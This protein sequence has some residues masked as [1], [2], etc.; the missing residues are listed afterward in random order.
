MSSRLRALLIPR[1]GGR[2]IPSCTRRGRACRWR[3]KGSDGEEMD[4]AIAM[5]NVGRREV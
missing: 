1:K 4:H 5:V 2:A 3:E